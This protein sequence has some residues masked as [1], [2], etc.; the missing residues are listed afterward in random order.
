MNRNTHDTDIFICEILFFF[1]YENI[2]KVIKR[3]GVEIKIAT[4]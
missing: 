1:V 3:T 4:F 2:Y